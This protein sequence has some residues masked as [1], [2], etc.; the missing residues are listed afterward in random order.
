MREETRYLKGSE[1]ISKRFG[2]CRVKHVC[3]D[4]VSVIIGD[5]P[6]GS[7]AD[8]WMKIVNNEVRDW[9]DET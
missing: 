9:K 6:I 4:R 8:Y 5:K 2:K 7:S 1:V 3:G